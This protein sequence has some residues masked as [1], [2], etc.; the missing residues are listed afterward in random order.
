MRRI[1]SMI[2]IAVLLSVTGIPML[3]KAA[4]CHAA[5]A[6]ADCDT[7]HTGEHADAMPMQHSNG[8]AMNHQMNSQMNHT[9][10]GNHVAMQQEPAMHQGHPDT[11]QQIEQSQHKHKKALSSA[12]KECRIECGCGCNRSADGLPNLLAP[13]IASSIQFETIGHFA[14]IEP[15]TYPGPHSLNLNN[16][17]PPP[18]TI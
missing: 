5:E 8:H 15:A 12:E 3:P 7:C 14:R 6:T 9:G 13:H 16:P 4:V 1:T 10:H 17:P 2:M 18:K 11:P